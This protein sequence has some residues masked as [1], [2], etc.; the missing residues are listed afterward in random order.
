MVF[1]FFFGQFGITSI[2]IIYF[3]RCYPS[4]KLSVPSSIISSSI[5]VYEKCNVTYL[6]NLISKFI[7]LFKRHWFDVTNMLRRMLL[8]VK[9]LVWSNVLFT[10]KRYLKLLLLL[11]FV[12][13][14]SRESILH[15]VVFDYCQSHM[16][17]LFVQYKLHS[18]LYE[19]MSLSYGIYNM[20]LFSFCTV[21]KE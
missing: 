12:F 5:I 15:V 1:F 10:K 6:K 21:P 14:P 7:S 13:W 18:F 17:F 3:Y 2:F 11:S 19:D 16:H 8:K 20:L 4:V 9:L